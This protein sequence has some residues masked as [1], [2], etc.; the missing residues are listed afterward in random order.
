MHMNLGAYSHK[1]NRH[2][3]CANVN[4]GITGM[5]TP[6]RAPNTGTYNVKG[7]GNAGANIHR[8]SSGLMGGKPPVGTYSSKGRG[9]A[10][11]NVHRGK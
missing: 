8:G 2:G 11:A 7:S 10:G 3:S 6:N 9:N 5:M 1:E 4:R